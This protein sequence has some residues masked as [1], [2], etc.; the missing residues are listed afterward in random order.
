MPPCYLGARG[1]GG[2]WL[3][4]SQCGAGRKDKERGG[5]AGK[6]YPWRIKENNI[7]T[8]QCFVQIAKVST[9]NF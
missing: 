2:G 8:R 5:K 6:T 4:E 9:V 3:E 1:G 7:L